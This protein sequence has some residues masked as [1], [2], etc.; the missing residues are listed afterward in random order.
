MASM[1]ASAYALFA[2]LITPHGWTRFG[3][4]YF[5]LLPGE[6]RTVIIENPAVRLKPVDVTA[7]SF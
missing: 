4:N 1:T 2:H 6:T 5:D 3:D 7:R